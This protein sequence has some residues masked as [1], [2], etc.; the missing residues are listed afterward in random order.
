[1]GISGSNQEIFGG[2]CQEKELKA[3]DINSFSKNRNV[4]KDA[5]WLRS[6]CEAI[7][8]DGVLIIH[9]HDR[10]GGKEEGNIWRSRSCIASE[11]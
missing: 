8:L 5:C 6:Q 3:S 11:V 4:K 9:L 10:Q 2:F 7:S 1:M